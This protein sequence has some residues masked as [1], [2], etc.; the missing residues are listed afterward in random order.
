MKRRMKAL[1]KALISGSSNSERNETL[2]FYSEWLKSI[3]FK[4]DYQPQAKISDW[5]CSM[6]MYV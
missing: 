3:L 2:D 4:S 6:R 5:V 1:F